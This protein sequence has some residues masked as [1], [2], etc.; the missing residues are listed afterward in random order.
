[1]L[2]PNALY[3]ANLPSLQ[4]RRDH[5]ARNFFT[6]ILVPDSFLHSL[7]PAPCGDK[8]LIF[9]L[10]LLNKTLPVLHKFWLTPLSVKSVTL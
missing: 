8:N 4:Q 5:Q 6:S 10:G 3:Y 7:L 9:S 1:M 2:Y